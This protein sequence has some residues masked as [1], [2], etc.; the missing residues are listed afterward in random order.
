MSIDAKNLSGID[1][2][3]LAILSLRLFNA[4]LHY[5]VKFY[6]YHYTKCG[7]Y[8]CE[9][10]QRKQTSY[11][12]FGNRNAGK[13]S[14]VNKIIGQ[15]LSIVSDTPGTTADVNQKS[16][17]LLPIGSVV[18]MDTAGVD[19]IGNLGALRVQKSYMALDRADVA[20]VVFD[21]NPLNAAD[22]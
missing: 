6:N 22:F 2:S 18:L 10:N 11:R 14:L 9:S 19:D 3:I 20:V 16:M 1:T 17:E 7:E 8:F 15:E 13:S 4:Y 12:F 21:N 5:T